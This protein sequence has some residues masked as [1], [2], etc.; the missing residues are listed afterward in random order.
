MLLAGC[1]D[2]VTASANT[3]PAASGTY[4]TPVSVTVAE[5]QRVNTSQAVLAGIAGPP[6]G[7]Q[8]LAAVAGAA[9]M[10]TS[11][12]AKARTAAKVPSTEPIG[13]T[14]AG[15][16]TCCRPRCIPRR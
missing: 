4:S 12:Q 5:A 13:G 15:T 3:V 9:R 11:L 16:V 6:A 2:G 7:A 8:P 10:T 14:A 1:K